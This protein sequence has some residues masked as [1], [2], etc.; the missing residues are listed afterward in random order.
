MADLAKLKD[1]YS[2]KPYA[3]L[4][5]LLSAGIPMALLSASM[6]LAGTAPFGD[7]SIL[8]YDANIQYLDFLS[9]IRFIFSGDASLLYSF[10]AGM[11]A[12]FIG[13]AAYYI[14]SPFNILFALIP[15]NNGVL[16]FTLVVL[17]KVGCCGLCYYCAACR[18]FG[19]RAVNLGFSTAYA[20]I[21]YNIVYISN[22]MWLDGVMMLPLVALGIYRIWTENKYGVYIASLIYALA[23]NYYIGYM[24]CVF[25]VMM[26]VCF[27][28]NIGLSRREK[29]CRFGKYT[30]ASL[31]SGFAAAPIWLPA[32]L[33]VAGSRVKPAS[34]VSLL[35]FQFDLAQLFAKLT[36]GAA[37]CEQVMGALPQVFCSIA[38]LF[39][40]LL[41]FSDR[42][43]SA[44]L[45]ITAGGV[46][47]FIL[48]GMAN[49]A[50][51][52]LWHGFA[53]TNGFNFRNSFILS[54]VLILIANYQFLRPKREKIAHI[55]VCA[56]AVGCMLVFVFF[57]GY[58]FTSRTGIIIG[59]VCLVLAASA[60]AAKGGRFDRFAAPL[61]S[62]VI[63]LDMCANCC[64]S[65]PR[66]VSEAD[67]ML[68][69]DFWA[70]VD[71]SLAPAE[72]VKENDK[73]FYRMES[74][75][76][77]ANND[78][79]FLGLNGISHYS[80]VKNDDANT[81]IGRMGLRNNDIW[82]LYNRGT[83]AEAESLLGIKYVLSPDA[84]PELK[85][86]E[87]IEDFGETGVYRNNNALPLFMLSDNAIESVGM[88]NADYFALHNDIWSG[89]TGSAQTLLH[90]ENDYSVTTQ[91]LTQRASEDGIVYTKINKDA[92][93]YVRYDINIS[94][95]LPLYFYFTAPK[96]QLARIYINGVDDGR[97]F[98]LYRWDMSCAGT[99]DEGDTLRI[100]IE[101]EQDEICITQPYFYYE[102]LDR[103]S[104][105]SAGIKEVSPYVERISD[106]HFTGS[107]TAGENTLLLT[108]IPY[109][110]G[111]T[112]RIDG[113]KVPT[114]KA[115]DAM[116]A[117]ALP[118]G[119]HQFEL[120]YFPRGLKEGF[121]LMG[122]SAALALMW[123]FAGRK[124]KHR[125]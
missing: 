39:L 117:A 111:W 56:A 63:I 20:L 24:L 4:L 119:E 102:D 33:S 112:L 85:G 12:G 67:H 31:I 54:F 17:L 83:T 108:T 61:V 121:V 71:N 3:L 87:L 35:L 80:S 26:S 30:L 58:D 42:G 72:Y 107:Y 46:V 43:N 60:A 68:I 76:A 47:A 55:A 105:V 59:A 86:Y 106:A 2:G 22:L 81:F 70:F 92:P 124:K 95:S 115:M 114:Q 78:P 109:E 34:E 104:E 25:S 116:L 5:M 69:Y 9:Y 82:A 98:W 110:D 48:L 21:A 77:R 94:R 123:A 122:V 89:I 13:L 41:F 28:A 8:F 32:I 29:L 19:R 118:E 88:G 75:A 37:D 51:Y 64:I 10:S 18:V 36:T 40:A 96:V 120:S 66:M 45:R 11:G 62:A 73:G 93:A 52:L 38:V 50:L 125:S 79:M 74:A 14:L 1:K 84:R 15:P 91:N 113:E 100:E 103:L 65:L 53:G 99:F 49:Y 27:M 57:K 6:F 7:D 101:L 90:K 23:A 97:Y 44:K 16:T